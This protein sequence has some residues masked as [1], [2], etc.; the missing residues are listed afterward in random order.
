MTPT[1][2]PNRRRRAVAVGAVVAVA[3]VG[4]VAATVLRPGAA[5][6]GEPVPGAAA[7][8]APA[9]A[10]CGVADP[11]RYTALD[12]DTAGLPSVVTPLVADV[13]AADGGTPGALAVTDDAVVALTSTDEA[14]TVTRYGRA[15]GREQGAFTL[16]TR[17]G[18]STPRSLVALDELVALADG[19]DV[20]GY[21]ADGDE[22]WRADL[23][24]LDRGAVDGVLPWSAG[25]D[26]AA[27]AVV[28]REAEEVALLGADGAV[29][30]ADGPAL[31]AGL[32]SVLDDGSL[33]V[34]TEPEPG[35]I[36]MARYTA[37]GTPDGEFAGT[38]EDEGANGRPALME[39]PVAVV[40]APDDDGYL[41]W[42]P[43]TRLVHTDDRGVWRGI[44][45]TGA[46]HGPGAV[47]IADLSPLVR[48][49]D[50]YYF[51]SAGE[52]GTAL[53]TVDTAGMRTVLEAP[54]TWDLATSYGT[55]RLGYGAGLETSADYD[56]FADGTT[57]AVT[58][59]FADWWTQV[60]D[61]LELRYRVTGDPTI[62]DAGSTTGTLDVP[63][64]GTVD[65]P[66]PAARPGAYEVHAELVERESGTVRSATCLRYAVGAPGDDLDPG[67]LS[68]SPDWGGAGPLR[69]VELA[70]R[71][72]FGVHRVQ[73]DL[74]RLIPDAGATPSAGGLDLSA[75]P[76]A[77]D[78][79]PFAGL[80]AAAELAEETGVE[81][82]VQLG[83]GGEA[84]HEAVAAGTW[85]AWVGVV[86]DAL[87]AGAPDLHTWAAWNEPNNTG[88]GDGGDYARRVLAPFA[89]AVRTAD[90]DAVV[91]DGN[92]LN[93]VV[94]WYRQLLEA[95]ACTDLDV[96]GIHPYTGFNRSWDEEG[97]DGPLG[98]IAE[99]KSVV[100]E[101]CGTELPMW[102]TESGWWVDGP[103][104]HWAQAQ[105]VARS[106]LWMRSL[107]VDEWLY[108]YSEGGWGEGNFSWALLQADAFVG[109]GA[110]A[111]TTVSGLLEGRPDP[112]VVD[113]DA[114]PHVHAVRT[115]PADGGDDDL[116]AVWTDDLATT[117][118]V[119]AAAAAEAR[120]TDLYGA[121]TS[122]D[123]P[124]GASVDLAVSGSPTYVRVPAGTDL[125]L[126][127]GELTGPDLLAGGS[128]SAS[129][130]ADGSDPA[131]LV[132]PEGAQ[133]APWTAGGRT[134]TG[135]DVSPWVTVEL[136]EP[137]TVDRV[138]V[139]SAGIRCCTS[140]LRTY[141]VSVQ[142]ADGG[143]WTEVATLDDVFAQ[144]TSVARFDPV[145][146]TAVRV[147]VP[148]TEIRGVTV[149][150]VA[151]SGQNG[152]LP[153]AWEP[154]QAVPSWPLKLLSVSA[155]GPG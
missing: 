15:D 11:A 98:Q 81:L 85:G 25:V 55:D 39:R 5:E 143:D 19:S 136:A 27:L 150:D 49:G 154:V 155:Y 75:L 16:D 47:S 139:S 112:V 48:A 51:L 138:V 61:G 77:A 57:P 64:G 41:V 92:A 18:G 8:G 117:V 46:G 133:A 89:A 95:G 134:G 45:L 63:A 52:D 22:S 121:T 56:Y 3:A 35:E 43:R 99:L 73:L 31:A 109:P 145:E 128:V 147:R 103:A 110:L 42:G 36:V 10:V 1:T 86:V 65:V 137:A 28:F 7:A 78:G 37:D 93:V 100:E 123:L 113:T 9:S 33:V 129:S 50:D 131:V 60:A 23:A 107:G 146:V 126:G 83:Q 88:F 29:V 106:M 96:L 38:A 68:D 69:G 62:A 34:R 54:V 120:V 140:G 59:R 149:P 104:N 122:L 44:V 151:Y 105:D 70:D 114:L 116:W 118:G 21:D 142:T 58:A 79:D 71:L 130:S 153:P 20:V 111:M 125:A 91:V 87:R 32:P 102:D 115:G 108:F 76:G 53:A 82:Y 40:T 97:T 135:P 66:L 119:T 30:E 144:R 13:A 6:P 17:A 24:D 127:G 94:P 90:P 80:A 148:S 26:G 84:E 4:V 14:A 2:S 132:D 72:G 152:G 12:A 67:S 124:A 141:A 101:V 74:S